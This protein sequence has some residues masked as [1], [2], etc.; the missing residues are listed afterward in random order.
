MHSAGRYEFAYKKTVGVL[1]CAV[2]TKS[3]RNCKIQ[4]PPDPDLFEFFIEDVVHEI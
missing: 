2:Q 1:Y 4:W 3:T